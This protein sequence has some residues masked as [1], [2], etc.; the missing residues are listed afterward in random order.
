[1][2]QKRHSRW[3]SFS[4]LFLSLSFSKLAY[5]IIFGTFGTF[6]A[7]HNDRWQSNDRHLQ[8]TG[9]RA[10]SVQSGKR[11][12]DLPRR[13]DINFETRGCVDV[14]QRTLSPVRFLHLAALRWFRN[15][16]WVKCVKHGS[17]AN[18]HKGPMGPKGCRH[19]DGFW[20]QELCDFQ[21]GQLVRYHV[22]KWC[23]PKTVDLEHWPLFPYV[24]I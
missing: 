21:S 20:C 11:S 24:S 8:L 1:M 10:E 15:V 5:L 7:F 12:W 6:G 9:Q 16:S 19:C 13:E 23:R 22:A 17:M 18:K 14:A 4:A 2:A 3:R